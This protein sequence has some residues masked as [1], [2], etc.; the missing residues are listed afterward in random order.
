LS[1]RAHAAAAAATA[2]ARTAAAAA[3]TSAAAAT[4]GSA[5]GTAT[6]AHELVREEV[7][8]ARRVQAEQARALA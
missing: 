1:T 5:R 3:R 6:H 4:V 2:A 7:V 8:L